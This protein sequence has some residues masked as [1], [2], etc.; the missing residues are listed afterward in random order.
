MQLFH[1]IEDSKNTRKVSCGG[2]KVLFSF[3][4]EKMWFESVQRIPPFESVQVCPKLNLSK[5]ESVQFSIAFNFTRNCD[6]PQRNSSYFQFHKKLCCSR[7]I[8]SCFYSKTSSKSK[9]CESFKKLA[10]LRQKLV[11]DVNITHALQFH[12]QK[13]TNFLVIVYKSENTVI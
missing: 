11:S 6:V 1:F 2:K 4:N 13:M 7:I 3:F 5:T 12:G 9:R 10:K 8:K